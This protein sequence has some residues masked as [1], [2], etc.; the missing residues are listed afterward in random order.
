MRSPAR[1]LALN[2]PNPST[3]R[4]S[5]TKAAKLE[6]VKTNATGECPECNR[7]HVTALG[8]LSSQKRREVASRCCRCR[9]W[10]QQTYAGGGKGNVENLHPTP[11]GFW[12]LS[13]PPSAGSNEDAAAE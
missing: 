1:P 8:G 13:F 7:F 4:C 11:E 2:S 10:Q 9:R 12:D 6:D 3:L 5:V